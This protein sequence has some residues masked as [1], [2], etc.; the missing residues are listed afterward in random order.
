MTYRI[1]IDDHENLFRAAYESMRKKKPLLENLKNKWRRYYGVD[2]VY[3]NS[4]AQYLDFKDEQ[5]FIMFVLN[6]DQNGR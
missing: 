3:E 1:N 4:R 5:H 2:L 6:V